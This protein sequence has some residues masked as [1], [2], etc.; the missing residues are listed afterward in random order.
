MEKECVSVRKFQGRQELFLTVRAID[1][2]CVYLSA[3]GLMILISLLTFS[4][5]DD[6]ESLNKSKSIL[7]AVSSYFLKDYEVQ[8]VISRDPPH[9]PSH[10]G[11]GEALYLSVSAIQVR[12]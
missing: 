5:Q 12:L 2:V 7:V 11:C 9:Y 8:T 1:K 6:P 4:M 10:P 3:Q